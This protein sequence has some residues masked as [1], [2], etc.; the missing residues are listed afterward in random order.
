MKNISLSTNVGLGGLV[1][2]NPP[3]VQLLRSV[4]AAAPQFAS[5]KIVRG[6]FH[7]AERMVI[8]NDFL[9]RRV[10]AHVKSKAFRDRYSQTI[11]PLIK[12]A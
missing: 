3:H 2:S 5:L 6:L 1:R 7:H 4:L 8:V 9:H 11:A 12:M 10:I